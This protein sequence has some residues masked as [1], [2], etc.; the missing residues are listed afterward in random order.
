MI[1][2]KHI[3]DPK[4]TLKNSLRTEY[5]FEIKP[6]D[7]LSTVFDILPSNA[8]INKGRCGIGGTYLETVIAQR[9]SIIIVPTNAIIDNKCFDEDGILKR[10]YYVARGRNKDFDSTALR[11]FMKDTTQFKKIFC[12]PESLGKIIKCG[13]A[14][15]ELYSNWFILFDEAHT[16]ITDAYRQNMLVAFNYFF[17]FDNKAM[18][19][20]TPYQF[21]S[22]QLQSFT[23]Y[24]IKFT[25]TVNTVEIISTTNVG[26]RLYQFLKHPEQ[27]PHRVHIF[28]NSVNGIAA[29]IRMANLSDC[30]IFC[31]DDP[32][33][34]DKLDE[35]QCYFNEN[36]IDS[37]FSKFNFYTTKYFEGWDLYDPNATL[38]VVSDVNNMTLRTGISNKCVQAMGRN[39]EASNKLIHLTND[40]NDGGFDSFNTIEENTFKT[41]YATIQSYML[42]LEECNVKSCNPDTHIYDSVSK[43]CDR[44]KNGDGITLNHYMVDRL[45]NREYCEQEYNHVDYIKIAWEESN[46]KVIVTRHHVPDIPTIDKRMSETHKIRVIV[47]YLEDLQNPSVSPDDYRFGLS[48]LQV[49]FEDI[50]EHYYELTKAG[51]EKYNYEPILLREAYRESKNK[52]GMA[53]V[54]LA[55]FEKFGYSEVLTHVAS[56]FLQMLY[57]QNM[58]IKEKGLPKTPKK[59]TASTLNTM[60]TKVTNTKNKLKQH[61]WRIDIK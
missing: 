18:I 34:M 11:E 59:A 56:D 54:A 17:K 2:G 53:L 39:R 27:F 33:N 20:A 49:D 60:F 21:S 12:T 22:P 29:A 43:Y 16:T 61:V 52:K 38:I 5:T 9:N 28:L 55:Y 35:L 19:S 26:S 6:D 30:S 37:S 31:K 41:A 51:M 44:E 4:E 13:Y 32:A 23:R 7:N 8:I 46:Y 3:I 47:N 42:H 48:E 57:L 25:S 15:N 24:N 1:Q 50:I 45:I 10:G 40:K 58:I 36:P 14:L